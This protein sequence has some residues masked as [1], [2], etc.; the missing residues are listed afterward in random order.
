VL[1]GDV[2]LQL[3]AV[4]LGATTSTSLP[5]QTRLLFLRL[6]A[7]YPRYRI[8]LRCCLYS[9]YGLAEIAIIG[10]DLAELLGS[11]IALNLYVLGYLLSWDQLPFGDHGMDYVDLPDYSRDCRSLLEC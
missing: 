9:L 5:S 2:V 4:R 3:L 10:T 11:A 7:K 1:M 6:E 8:P